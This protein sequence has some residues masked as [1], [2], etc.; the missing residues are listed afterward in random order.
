VPTTA[1]TGSEVTRFATLYRGSRKVSLDADGVQADTAVIDPALTDSCPPRLTWS[2][3]FDA[4][5]HA[6]ESL[7][8]LRSTALSRHYAET[9]LARLVP[10]L[11]N[12]G[13][14][15]TEQE[16]DRL[17]EAGTLAGHAI[18]ITRTTAA[19]ALAYPLT[20]HLGVPHGFACALNLVWL[21]PIVERAAADSTVDGRGAEAAG[22]AI[23]TLR[24]L[25]GGNAGGLGETIR[26]LLARRGMPTGRGT[27]GTNPGLVGPGLVDLVVAEGLSSNRVSGMPIR[28]DPEQVRESIVELLGVACATTG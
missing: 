2:C 25:L 8:S 24:R 11:F 7:W 4:L 9:A 20:A 23:D 6:V 19:H 15:P 27:G 21:V 22:T 13:D 17:S 14:L 26:T 5:A 12:A 18:D 3:A 1:G 16:R 28:L 10:V